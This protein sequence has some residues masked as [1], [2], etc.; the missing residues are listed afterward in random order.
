MK[1]GLYEADET[2]RRCKCGS[3]ISRVLNTWETVE[4]VRMRKRL[5]T[6]CKREF[7]TSTP[8]LDQRFIPD[9]ITNNKFICS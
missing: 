3:T 4:G 6:T 2:P 5:C 1:Y 7:V 8:I 9:K